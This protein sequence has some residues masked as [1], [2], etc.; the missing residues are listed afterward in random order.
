MLLNC[1]VGEDPRE[2]LTQQGDPTSPSSRRSVLSVHWKDWHW[3]WNSNTLATWC[4][5][6]IHLKRPWCWERLK[7]KRRRVQQRMRGLDGIT[8][9]MEMSLSKLR[10]L[11]MDRR[12]WHAVVHGVM[13]SRTW[14]SDWTEL[15]NSWNSISKPS[16]LL[17]LDCKTNCLLKL[18]FMELK[19]I[20]FYV[21]FIPAVSNLLLL[22]SLT[23]RIEQTSVQFSICKFLPCLLPTLTLSV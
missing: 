16:I 20:T 2:C 21:K 4:K 14:V 11:V 8:D 12:A 18:G 5:E 10:E 19:M 22:F 3:S 15:N 9:S 6:L 23:Q 7:A 13:K 17:I 1:G